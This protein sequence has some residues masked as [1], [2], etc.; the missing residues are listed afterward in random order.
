MTVSPL[1][2]RRPSVLPLLAALPGVLLATGACGDTPQGGAA[3]VPAA[4]AAP[5]TATPSSLL[6]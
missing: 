1:F 5:D 6:R 2:S 4:A 3:D